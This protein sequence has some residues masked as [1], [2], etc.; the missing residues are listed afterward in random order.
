MKLSEHSTLPK[1]VHV[2]YGYV[3]QLSNSPSGFTPQHFNVFG[4]ACHALI[5]P[6]GEQV[7]HFFV[8]IL[9]MCSCDTIANA[10]IANTIAIRSSTSDAHQDPDHDKQLAV[11][12]A[13][14]KS[15]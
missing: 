3:T 2:E 10:V 12:I 9:Y 5:T 13:P 1:D 4:G 15:V 8:L 6:P 7:L 11:G 14:T